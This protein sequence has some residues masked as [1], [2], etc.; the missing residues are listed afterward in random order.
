VN[1]T[2][3]PTPIQMTTTEAMQDV[4]AARP[5]Q[6]ALWTALD[7]EIRTNQEHEYQTVANETRTVNGM[8]LPVEYQI[9]RPRIAPP[10][11][12]ARAAFAPYQTLTAAEYNPLLDNIR[13][14]LDTLVAK[15]MGNMAALPA[16]VVIILTKA[17]GGVRQQAVYT[18]GAGGAGP[19]LRIVFRYDKFSAVDPG[20]RDTS[21]AGRESKRSRRS[22]GKVER[23]QKATVIHEMGHMLHAF[24]DMARFQAAAV[25]PASA[26]AAPAAIGPQMHKI[27]TVN[28]QVM[29]ALATK[30]Y[31]GKW[32][33]AQANPA[34]VV[35]EVWTALMHGRD[36]PRG[37][38]AV[39]L[40][41]GGMR[42]A[43]I[44]D[45]LRRLFP[46]RQM[47]TLNEPEDALP[48]I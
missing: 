13:G 17:S 29:D 42:N 22:A 35:A 44:D 1:V 12:P 15:Y 48:Y 41:Y 3:G 25:D 40:A 4:A 34:E 21:M 20:D 9:T 5:D 24:G 7:A 14:A 28:Q 26:A 23:W 18:A 8:A 46:S 10:Q 2:A 31:K 6:T 33:Y 16:R 36:V 45:K 43:A 32:Q 27:A 30:G 47:P 11:S 39:Y 37:L 19:T 38:A